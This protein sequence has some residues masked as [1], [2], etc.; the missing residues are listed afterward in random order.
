M[1]GFGEEIVVEEAVGEPVA[2][3]MIVPPVVL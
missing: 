3:D 2:A 1:G